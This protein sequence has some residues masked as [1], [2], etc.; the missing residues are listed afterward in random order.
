[1]QIFTNNKQS[2]S[3]LKEIPFKL[4]RE[5]QNLFEQNLE[6]LSSLKLVKS[7]FSIQNR[8]IDTLAFDKESNAFVIIEYKRSQNYS[9]VDQGVSYLNLMLEYRADFIVEYN[10]VHG[11]NLKRTDVDWSQSRIMFVSP[12]FTDFQKQSTN[13]KDL[14]IELWEIK[15]LENQIVI[16]NQIGKSK[17]APS[18]RQVQRNDGSEIDKVVREIKVYTEDDHLHGK[19]DDIRELYETFK[20]AILNLSPDM[21][22]DPK[23]LYIA[24]K[25]QKN[26][27]DVE[28]QQ[29]VLKLWINVKKGQLKDEKRLAKDVSLS[30]HWGNGDYGIIVTDTTNLEYIMSLVKQALV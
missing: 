12:S 11:E 30:G 26:I 1:M 13:F 5:I 27:V 22:V 2:L 16:V 23:K 15:Q 29:K 9:V 20:N 4:E 28:I 14:G 8:R 25:K 6:L 18:I 19:N 7:E 24:F 10:E 3:T 17:S 21:D